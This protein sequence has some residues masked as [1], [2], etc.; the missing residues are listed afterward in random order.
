[1]TKQFGFYILFIIFSA[2]ENSLLANA[3][4]QPAEMLSDL[5]IPLV[6]G[7]AENN[8][9]R[10]V[11]DSPA[12]SIINA[13]AKGNA[14][15]DKV[16]N[17]YKVVLPSLSWTIISDNE[18]NMACEEAADFCIEAVRDTESLIL[19]IR[20]ENNSSIVNYALSPK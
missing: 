20:S 15:S 10:V 18:N 3:Q 6:S 13:E 2:I 17:Y 14:T 9:A 5:D 1:M 16:Y 12:G 19:Q 11:F 4:N 8:D 7:F